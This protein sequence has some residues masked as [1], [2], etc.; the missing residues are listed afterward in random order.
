M[1]V[2]LCATR[3]HEEPEPGGEMQMCEEIPSIQDVSEREQNHD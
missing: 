2:A 1:G 3:L